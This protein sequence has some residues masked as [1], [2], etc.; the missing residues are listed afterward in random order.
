MLSYS[1]PSEAK[2]SG[3]HLA[4]P[5]RLRHYDD[6]QGIVKSTSQKHP[7]MSLN[8]VHIKVEH[9]PRTYYNGSVIIL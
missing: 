1:E 5:R 3:P 6:G 8:T 4:V 7:L 2:S 9:S